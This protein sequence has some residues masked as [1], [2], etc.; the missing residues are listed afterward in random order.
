MV[1]P[2]ESSDCLWTINPIGKVPT[3]RLN[4]GS[5]IFDSLIIYDYLVATYVPDWG[6]E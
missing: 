2:R 1:K 5:A 4:D 6:L 3:L